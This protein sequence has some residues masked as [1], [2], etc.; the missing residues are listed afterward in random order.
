MFKIDVEKAEIID[1]VASAE[2]YTLFKRSGQ[3]ICAA[4]ATGFVQ[5][6]DQSNLSVL[7][8]WKAHEGWINDMDANSNFLVTC[9]WSPNRQVGSMPD[10]LAKV[11]DLKNLTPLAPIPFYLGAA[12][13]R[14]HPRMITTAVI[15]GRN[16]QVQ[17][18]DIKKHNIVKMSMVH[19]V[20]CYLTALEFASSSEAMALSDSS[21]CIQVWGSP[22]GIR[23]TTYGTESVFADQEF[24]TDFS[25]DWDGDTP[26]NTI[27]MPYYRDVLLSAWPSNLLFE[28][29]APPAK[30]DPDILA[31]LTE[32]KFGSYAPNPRKKRRNQ[33]VNTRLS[34]KNA[35]EGPRF[36]SEQAK[37]GETSSMKSRRMSEVLESLSAATIDGARQADVPL[38]YRSL[39]IKYSKFGV[40]DFDFEYFNKTEFSGLE[41]HITHSYVNAL[42]QLLKYTPLIRN[43]ALQHTASPCLSEIC[44]LCEMGFLFDMLE[45]ASGQNCQATNFLKIFGTLPPTKQLGL[46][47]DALPSRPTTLRM[48]AANRFVMDKISADY[49][50]ISAQD[51]RMEQVLTTTGYDILRC[52]A[53]SVEHV[54]KPSGTYVHDLIYPPRAPSKPNSPILLP[55]F[56]QVLKASVEREATRAWCNRCRLYRKYHSKK[57]VQSI[58]PVLNLNAVLPNINP[59]PL[60]ELGYDPNQLWARIGWLPTEIGIIIDQGQFFCYEGQDLAMHLQRGVFKIRVYELIGVVADINSGEHQKSHPV[61]LINISPSLR[62]QEVEN[63]WH[64]FN[65][66]LVRRV[67]AEEALHFDPAWKLPSVLTYQEK[68]SRHAIDNSWKNNLDV[69]VLYRG[70]SLFDPPLQPLHERPQPGTPVGIDAEFVSLQQEELEIKPDGSRSVLRP[71]RLGLARVSVLRGSN[72]SFKSTESS[73]SSFTG[74]DAEID[75]Q[76]PPPFTPFIDDYVKIPHETIVD[77]LTL[78]SGISPG[79]LEPK[80][81][82]YDSTGR[83]VSLKI[84]YKK[85]WLLLN[86]GCVF[87]GHGLPKDFR[88]INIHV[89]KRQ[90]VD[91]VDL[92]FDKKKA[93][94]L[95]LRFLSWF[96]LG[97]RV[98]LTEGETTGAAVSTA[99]ATVTATGSTAAAMG[100]EAQPPQSQQQ[101]PPQKGHDSVVDARMA[102]R[103][104]DKWRE[105][106]EQGPAITEK[107]IEEIYRRGRE[108]GFKVPAT[109]S[110]PP[111][112]V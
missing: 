57:N 58:P 31:N 104:W 23:F 15:A 25:I 11:F 2:F 78:Y 5:L 63:H 39:E 64:L 34:E 87:V 94:K 62:R 92:F 21:C 48:Q 49:C 95:S 80:I 29:G 47:E 97:E 88:T 60:R 112:V 37:E 45:K 76:G 33:A 100:G 10:P 74:P 38:I 13:V 72:S 24:H 86:L 22:A 93:R 96:L 26:L 68:I 54:T 40:E 108:Y 46:R 61:S 111:V 73:P 55:S 44:L 30:L 17:F 77:Y 105:L 75:T 4:T 53:C 56:S 41:T 9:G 51:R 27:G 89:P 81:S 106:Q 43:L 19:L 85:L 32:T 109:G 71:S 50:A 6:L 3:Y 12:Y 69:S 16:G 91:T 35:F 101:H 42:L 90:V 70:L 20:D 98:Q 66:F 110:P 14:M 1:S 65:D 103:L 8:S 52:S 7:R 83:L 18:V 67:T 107:V 99:T 28:V 59:P 102:L 79:D 36:L 84:A 82:P